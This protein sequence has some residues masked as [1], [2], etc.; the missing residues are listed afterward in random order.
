MPIT[1]IV[2][3]HYLYSG[4]S[5]KGH[6]AIKTISDNGQTKMHQLDML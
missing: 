3:D 5:D 4:T 1:V 2:Y 6:S